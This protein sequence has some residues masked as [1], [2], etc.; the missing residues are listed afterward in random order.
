MSR[1]SRG[2]E[3]A[4]AGPRVLGAAPNPAWTRA[5]WA[6]VPQPASS[7]SLSS[8]QSGNVPRRAAGGGASTHSAVDDESVGVGRGGRNLRMPTGRDPV[9][10]ISGAHGGATRQVEEVIRAR[11]LGGRKRT[12]SSM[13]MPP[14]PSASARAAMP[15][16]PPVPVSVSNDRS[17]GSP[18]R[19]GV[20]CD[21]DDRDTTLGDPGAR[22]DPVGWDTYFDRAEDVTVTRVRMDEHGHGGGEASDGAKET[23]TFRVYTAGGVDASSSS[24]SLPVVF[25][26]HGCPYSGLSWALMARHLVGHLKAG[27]RVAAMDLRGHGATRT[28]DDSDFSAARLVAD[29]VAVTRQLYGRGEGGGPEDGPPPRVILVGHS[30]GGAVAARAAALRPSEGIPGLAGLVVVDVVEGTAMAA[31]PRMAAMVLAE[32]SRPNHFASMR[33]A[34]KWAVRATG[35]S[36]RNLEAARVS[37]PSQLLPVRTSEANGGRGGVGGDGGEGYRWRTDLAA[38]QPHWAGWYSG[39]SATFLSAPCPKLLLLAGT[40]RLDVDLTVAQMQGKF[41]M[42]LLPQAGHAL[43]EDEPR[44]TAEAVLA[45]AQ[46][47]AGVKVGR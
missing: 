14:P 15:P 41:Q 38:T 4:P 1:E 36:T 8:A 23:D 19:R 34:I 32:G 16:P 7:S 13:V 40:D 20:G 2:A 42:V 46:R 25:C 17:G 28:T 21:D 30:M 33:A 18:A 35:G 6:G 12:S 22:F 11:A 37:F 43:Q 3:E 9:G 27:C 39:L 5:P 26:I 24:A 29:V 31:L 44:K 45:F 47:Y 10:V